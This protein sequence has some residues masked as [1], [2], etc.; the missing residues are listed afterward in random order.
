MKYKTIIFEIKDS[1]ALIKLNRPDQYNSL[2]ELMA[3]ELLEISYEWD[4]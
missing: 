3:R 2:N 4:F 1:I